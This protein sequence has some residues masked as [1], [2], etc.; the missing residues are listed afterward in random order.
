MTQ[1]PGYYVPPTDGL[2]LKEEEDLRAAEDYIRRAISV[3][4]IRTSNQTIGTAGALI[5]WQSTLEDTGG[6][7]QPGQ[8]RLVVPPEV[9]GWYLIACGVYSPLVDFNSLDLQL[10]WNGVTMDQR[11]VPGGVGLGVSQNYLTLSVT[12]FLMLPLLGGDY[13]EVFLANSSGSSQTISPGDFR[14]Y[15]ALRRLV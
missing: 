8:S 15:L 13:I 1:S 3:R 2:T 11:P 6:F 10:R 4:A 7:W 14:T 5:V 9:A 12:C